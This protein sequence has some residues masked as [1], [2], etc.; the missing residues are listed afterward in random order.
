VGLS[1]VD[2]R[3]GREACLCRWCDGFLRF[4]LEVGFCESSVMW[5]FI[6]V[7]RVHRGATVC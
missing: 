7:L 4:I 2:V 3:V 6:L 1:H 5:F